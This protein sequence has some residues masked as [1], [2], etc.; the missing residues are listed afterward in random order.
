[1]K[2]EKFHSLC[3]EIN[4]PADIK[5]YTHIMQK[6]QFLFLRIKGNKMLGVGMILSLLKLVQQ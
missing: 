3:F 2:A 4:L 6:I 1:M 5:K